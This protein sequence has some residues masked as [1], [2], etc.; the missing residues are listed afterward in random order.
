VTDI[1]R[2]VTGDSPPRFLDRA[3]RP[4]AFAQPGYSHF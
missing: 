2:I 4:L 3:G 1:G